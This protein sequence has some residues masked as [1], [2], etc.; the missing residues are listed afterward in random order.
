M[1]VRVDVLRSYHGLS[2]HS[3]GVT[4]ND[5]LFSMENSAFFLLFSFLNQAKL[6]L[7]MRGYVRASVGTSCAWLQK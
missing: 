2:F 6:G 7:R 5:S 1:V 4:S 3:A